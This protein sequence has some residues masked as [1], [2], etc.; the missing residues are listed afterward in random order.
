MSPRHPWAEAVFV[1]RQAETGRFLQRLSG[2]GGAVISVTGPGGIGKSTLVRHWWGLAKDAGAMALWLDGR[3]GGHTLADFL[4]YIRFVVQDEYGE[5]FSPDEPLSSRLAALFSRGPTVILIDNAESLGIAESWL[6]TRF[7]PL[8]VTL[9]V[10]WVLASRKGLS[11]AWTTDPVLG[12]YLVHQPVDLWPRSHVAEYLRRRG[13]PGREALDVVMQQTGGHPLAVAMAADVMQK[14]GTR[15]VMALG[16][17]RQTIGMHLLQE[18]TVPRLMPLVE[19]LAVAREADQSTLGALLDRPVSTADYLA[20]SRLSFLSVTERG[21]TIHDVVRQLLVEDL[22]QRAPESY[23]VL[24]AKTVMVLQDKYRHSA[25]SQKI[26]LVALFTEL[27]REILPNTP[28]LDMS[29]VQGWAEIGN[30]SVLPADLPHLHRLLPPRQQIDIVRAEDQHAL[31]DDLFQVCPEGIRVVRA[32]D[33]TPLGFWACVW[34]HHETLPLLEKYAPR[35]FVQWEKDIPDFDARTRESAD[36]FFCVLF[37][38]DTEHPDYPGRHIAGQVLHDALCINGVGT[39]SIV[40]STEPVFKNI[41]ASLG[42][43]RRWSQGGPEAPGAFEI[44]EADNRGRDFAAWLVK[45]IRP[46][47]PRNGVANAPFAIGRAETIRNLEPDTV[48]MLLKHVTDVRY[49]GES[50]MALRLGMTGLQLQET[51]VGWLDRDDP[52]WPLTADDQ[53]LLKRAFFS[54]GVTADGHAGA[55]H[56]GRTTYYRRLAEAIDHFTLSWNR[57]QHGAR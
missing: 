15:Q 21:L 2:P 52:P 16:P 38:F 25:R 37:C 4:H 18:V 56:I 34:L 13:M 8:F 3:A 47:V 41:L 27:Y 40:L 10:L 29:S 45:K 17:I 50:A 33:G 39:R 24:R 26:G 14:A 31:L 43:S 22:R 55:L 12:P 51:L 46:Y 9:P 32:P 6:R 53:A 42:L 49:L 28:F 19:A 30:R 36:S 48:R 5:R 35:F 1:G 20:L 11:L 54:R 7:L 44:L 23:E 57:G